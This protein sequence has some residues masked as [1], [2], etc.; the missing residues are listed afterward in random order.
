MAMERGRQL[1]IAVSVSVVALFVLLIV[2]IGR[3]FNTGQMSPTGGLA[4]VGAIAAFVLVM[5]AVGIGL[6]Y[7]LNEE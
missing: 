4:L 2:L 3:A 5:A 7:W 6:A 1:E